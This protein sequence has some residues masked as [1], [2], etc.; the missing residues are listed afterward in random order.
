MNFFNPV[1]LLSFAFLAVFGES[2]FGAPRQFLGAQIDLLPALMVYAALH[3][4]IFT[5]SLVAVMG[6]LWFDALSANPL[7]VSILPLFLVAFPIHLHRELILRD[8][9]FAQFTLGAIASAVSPA[10]VLMILLNSGHQ[11]A[12]GWGTF[13]QWIVMTVGGALATP[14]IFAFFGWCRRMLGYELRKE[15][16]FRADRE[17]RHHRNLR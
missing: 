4:N 1:M 16:S 10:L 8:L 17:I 9:P 2:V 15:V 14:L 13:W 7:G 11:P 6:G 12:V 5:V 3:T